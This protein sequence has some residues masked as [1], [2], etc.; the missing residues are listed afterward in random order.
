[1][2][3]CVCVRACVCVWG[4]DRGIMCM[5]IGGWEVGVMSWLIQNCLRIGFLHSTTSF[6]NLLMHLTNSYLWLS[7]VNNTTVMS[8]QKPSFFYNVTGPGAFK[9]LLKNKHQYLSSEWACVQPEYARCI[10]G[11]KFRDN[12]EGGKEDRFSPS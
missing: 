9:N 10:W 4:G 3:V 8:F 7:V 1:M 5:C 2:E 6:Q 12:R 11:L